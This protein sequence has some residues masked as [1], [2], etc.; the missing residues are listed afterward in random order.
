MFT[1]P[2]HLENNMMPNLSL[3]ICQ[4]LSNL[5]KI[6]NLE[7]VNNHPTWWAKLSQVSFRESYTTSSHHLQK[8]FQHKP[9][10]IETDVDVVVHV[11]FVSPKRTRIAKKRKTSTGYHVLYVTC[12]CIHHPNNMLFCW[13]FVPIHTKQLGLDLCSAE[14]HYTQSVR[15]RGL[16]RGH[17]AAP[18][19]I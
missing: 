10:N 6:Q 9:G 19:T 2:S 4:F 15:G 16:E 3:G 14:V 7:N 8:H 12:G 5:G 1:I 13:Y 18:R 17:P 11:V